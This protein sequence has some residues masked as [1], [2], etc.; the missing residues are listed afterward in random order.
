MRVFE[1]D[2]GHLGHCIT[3]VGDYQDGTWRSRVPESGLTRSSTVSTIARESGL[4]LGVL[5]CPRFPP[6]SAA[7]L[8][9]L[10]SRMHWSNCFPP[11]ER[12]TTP[13]LATRDLLVEKKEHRLNPFFC[14]SIFHIPI[15]R[16]IRS[17]SPGAPHI[18][19]EQLTSN[20]SRPATKIILFCE[21]CNSPMTTT[22]CTI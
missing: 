9:P 14:P 22:L 18:G 16:T 13:V 4:L 6:P 7:A 15:H 21:H 2:Y 10:L 19:R 8:I 12:K 3:S 11:I 20:L 17:S 1:G 5:P